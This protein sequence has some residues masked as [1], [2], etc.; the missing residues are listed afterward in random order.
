ML[1]FFVFQPE[2]TVVL[3]DTLKFADIFGNEDMQKE[4]FLYFLLEDKLGKVISTNFIF[5][6][7]LKNSYG[8]ID[9]HI[10]VVVASNRCSFSVS[11][12]SLE[13]K[14]RAPAVFVYLQINNS[15]IESYTLSKNGYIQLEPIQMIR[16]E[17]EN[18]NCETVLPRRDIRILTIN[19]FLK[20]TSHF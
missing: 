16:L 10:D 8:I 3:Q 7:K 18:D 19:D 13:V 17:F 5:P 11:Q 12:I 9:P 14:A 1:F 15:A 4:S 2:N 6:E 20:N